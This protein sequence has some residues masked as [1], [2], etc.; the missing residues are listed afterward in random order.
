MSVRRQGVY[1]VSFTFTPLLLI[2]LAVI[3]AEP[4]PV[5]FSKRQP[6]DGQDLV[7]GLEV[8]AR[9]RTV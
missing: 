4:L 6:P 9:L 7:H 1:D 8:K 2:N 3:F 5:F